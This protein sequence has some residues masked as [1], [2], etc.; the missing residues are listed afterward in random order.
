MDVNLNIERKVEE[1]VF[2]NSGVTK[3]RIFRISFK[4]S[5]D[6]WELKMIVVVGILAVYYFI[7]D[8][9]SF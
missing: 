4:K 6:V 8:R 5:K 9:L 7:A 2:L 1:M 3:D